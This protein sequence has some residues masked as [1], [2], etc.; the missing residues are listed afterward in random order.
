MGEEDKD[1]IVLDAG[2]VFG[3]SGFGSAAQIK[4][5]I[6]VEGMEMM[7]YNIFNFGNNDFF[8]GVDNLLNYT[9]Q[10]NVPTI[11]ANVVYEDT[12]ESIAAP[13]K[14]IQFDNLK[15]GLIGIVSQ[16][17]ADEILQSTNLNFPD[18]RRIMV[19]NE[20]TVLQT[21]IDNIKNDV[22]TIIVLANVGMDNCITI[23]E[24]IEG[25]DAIIC[26]NGFER[27]SLLTI[28]GVHI[29]KSGDQGQ[30]VGNL[31]LRFDENNNLYDA[32]GSLVLL[33]DS[34]DEDAEL[35]ALMDEYHDRLEAVKDELLNLEQVDPA[36][37]GYYAGY[38]TCAECHTAQTDQWNTTAHATAFN[39][40]V[41][42]GNEY[43]AECFYCHTNGYGYTGGF[44]MPDTTPEME[45]VQCEM[46]HG[47][48]GTS[49]NTLFDPTS[50]STCT[51]EC[52]TQER[53]PNFNYATYY[54]QV[55]HS[56]PTNDYDND[57]INDDVDNCPNAYN[58]GQEDADADG[59]GD[60]CDNCLAA[61]NGPDLG[62]CIVG[63]VGNYC[64][65]DGD[66]GAGGVCS[67]HQADSDGDGIGDAC[68][69]CWEVINPDQLDSNSN[70]PAPSYGTDPL[71]GDACDISQVNISVEPAWATPGDVGVKV[72]LCLDNSDYEAGGVQ[73]DVCENIDGEPADC[74]T[75]VGC[76]MTERTVLFDCFVYELVSG[77]CRVIILS[78]N[79][80]GVI[81]PGICSIV[82]ID[83][84][85]CN[86]L[87]PECPEECNSVDCITLTPENIVIADPYGNPLAA[88]GIAGELCPFE[89]GD[90]YPPESAP[91][92]KDCGDGKVD[93]VD[94]IT[95]VDFALGG[96]T[97][98]EC[99]FIRADVP[100]GTPGYG[101]PPYC[102]PPD[103]E[104]NVLDIMV[105]IDM[106][107][108]R[109]DCCT[110]YYTGGIF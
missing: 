57:G 40:L 110:Y 79:P 74:L 76:E 45:G 66:C 71:C 102:T 96:K 26:G 80:G 75:C 49:P 30:N 87:N 42:K 25:I 97:P 35:L 51:A 85:F 86:P 34:H 68:D 60:V 13:N 84:E 101:D 22:D 91:G 24:A 27:E 61:P 8:F 106:A 94:I 58:P 43:N 109:Q 63:D 78:K 81:N 39:T 5:E 47:A 103:G 107:L 41:G 46:C 36:L 11:N 14:I 92:E 18:S 65:S 32:E 10:F 52:H 9:D 95:G 16:E 88:G 82:K 73:V 3:S 48:G 23:A 17:Y 59:V 1:V 12:G 7:S 100:T 38:S 15:V 98:D 2:N 4:A 33:D 6:A 53:D 50:E 69:N 20:T 67:M 19:L 29:V 72:D 90:V 28:N 70:C 54:P 37:G 104:L 105:L 56:H 83:Y 44:V 55:I 108:D 21:E 93:L 99:Q 89:C 62:I 64:M 31:V 77:C